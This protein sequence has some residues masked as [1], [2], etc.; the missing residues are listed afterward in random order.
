MSAADVFQGLLFCLARV[1]LAR[2]PPPPVSPRFSSP[3]VS[4]LAFVWQRLPDAG[5]DRRQLRE[6]LHR[7]R[8]LQVPASAKPATSVAEKPTCCLLTEVC[9]SSSSQEGLQGSGAAVEEGRPHRGH[10]H[11][12]RARLQDRHP[13]LRGRGQPAHGRQQSGERGAEGQPVR[14]SM[15]RRCAGWDT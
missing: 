9:F 7:H 6:N 11:G 8:R 14:A 3:S 12:V 13:A 15:A 2:H 5:E 1:L 10:P 4:P